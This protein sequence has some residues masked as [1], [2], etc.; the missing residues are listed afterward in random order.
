MNNIDKLLEKFELGTFDD[1]DNGISYDV[2]PVKIKNKS[3]DIPKKKR[4]KK[5][6]WRK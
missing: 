6:F 5:S 2:P 1:I 3:L 4:F